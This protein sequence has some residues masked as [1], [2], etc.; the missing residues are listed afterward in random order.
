MENAK[1]ITQIIIETINTILQNL[2]S[3]IDNNLYE[4]LDDIIF[5]NQDIISD[6]FF[7]KILGANSHNGIILICNSLLFGFILYYSIKYLFSHFNYNQIEKPS[8]FIFKIIIFGICINFS[9]FFIKEILSFTSN[10]TLAIRGIGEDLFNKNICFSELILEINKSIGIS[11]SSLDVFSLD[12]IIK[13]SL[14]SSLLSLVFTYAFRYIMV[15][16]FILLTPVAFLS[17]ILQNTYWFFKSW[18][19][20]LFSLLFIQIIVSLVLLIL[21]SMDYSSG[22]LI[23]KFI[24]IGAIYALIKAN[25]FSREFLGG[26]ST[27]ISQNV[28]NFF[29]K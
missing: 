8:Q 22:N 23:I 24:Y 20:N 6:S 26:V 3:S 17:L 14:S 16:I 18:I 7:E 1:N 29:K 5:I 27:T 2:F 25:S 15:K 28:N 9:Y 10:I 12:G 13:I 19:R 11:F 4:I 21:F